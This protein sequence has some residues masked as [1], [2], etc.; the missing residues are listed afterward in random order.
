VTFQYTAGK[1][2]YLV[3]QVEIVQGGKVMAQD[4]HAAIAAKESKD[5]VYHLDLLKPATTSLIL[6]ATVSTD[7]GNNSAGRIVVEKMP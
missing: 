7:A 2:R 3:H 5:N 1:S 6:R 4:K